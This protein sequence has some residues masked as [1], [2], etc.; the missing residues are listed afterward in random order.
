[1]FV[2]LDCPPSFLRQA[3]VSYRTLSVEMVWI[4]YYAILSS[5]FDDLHTNTWRQE[6]NRHP[7]LVNVLT[8]HDFDGEADIISRAQ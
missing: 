1:M 4:V 5:T 7:P 6:V 3:L 2:T 8:Y